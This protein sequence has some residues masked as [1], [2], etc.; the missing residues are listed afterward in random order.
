MTAFRQL[1]DVL[2][3]IAFLHILKN[4]PISPELVGFGTVLILLTV[5]VSFAGIYE[6]PSFSVVHDGNSELMYLN[7]CTQWGQWFVNQI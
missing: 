2:R 1:F 3:D 5:V 6:N 7:P 4:W